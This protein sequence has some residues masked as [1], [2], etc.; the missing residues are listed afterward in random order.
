[1]TVDLATRSVGSQ[2]SFGK[3]NHVSI[4][5]PDSPLSVSLPAHHPCPLPCHAPSS[6]SEADPCRATVTLTCPCGRIRQSAPC[7]RSTSNLSREAQQVKCSNECLIA[8]RNAR[9]AEALG[10]NP[11]SREKAI[12]YNEELTALAR[13][14]TKFLGLVEKSFAEYAMFSFVMAAL[15]ILHHRF[16]ASEKKTQV[17]PHMPMERRKFVHDVGHF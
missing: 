8:K 12:T 2:E 7:G 15:L 16:V 5:D 10:I 13:A 17:L 3:C 14:N 9:L 11:E 1:M 6:C 4:I